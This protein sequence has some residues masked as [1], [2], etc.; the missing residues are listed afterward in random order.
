MIQSQDLWYVGIFVSS[1]EAGRLF[2]IKET[3]WRI[4]CADRGTTHARKDTNVLAHSLKVTSRK[5]PFWKFMFST[6]QYVCPSLFVGSFTPVSLPA[7]QTSRTNWQHFVQCTF[8]KDN[9]SYR[10]WKTESEAFTS[11]NLL[12]LNT[13]HPSSENPFCCNSPIFPQNGK[14]NYPSTNQP[15]WDVLYQN[16]TNPRKHWIYSKNQQI[17]VFCGHLGE[18]RSLCFNVRQF[19]TTHNSHISRYVQRGDHK[20]QGFLQQQ[21][22]QL[23]R[24]VFEKIISHEQ[25][26]KWKMNLSKGQ[27]NRKEVIHWGIFENSEVR[28]LW[29]PEISGEATNGKP[30]SKQGSKGTPD[31]DPHLIKFGSCSHWRATGVVVSHWIWKGHTRRTLHPL[32]CPNNF[33]KRFRYMDASNQTDLL[34]VYSSWST[35]NPC[36]IFNHLSGTHYKMTQDKWIVNYTNHKWCEENTK[37]VRRFCEKGYD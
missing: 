7:E 3:L 30:K 24:E 37:K 14:T 22:E 12:R 27:T 23:E 1:V 9:K 6:R 11:S 25:K 20:A 31:V 32:D 8:V 17:S 18:K 28:K 35:K 15:N 36:F 5:M 10:L 2:S 19:F 21:N 13:L 29:V 33:N 4:G 16:W 34:V 26:L